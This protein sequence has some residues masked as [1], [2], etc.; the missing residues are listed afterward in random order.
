[1]HLT[2]S[3]GIKLKEM[4]NI[5]IGISQKRMKYHATINILPNMNPN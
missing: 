1:M 2:N 3:S 5:F 4:E